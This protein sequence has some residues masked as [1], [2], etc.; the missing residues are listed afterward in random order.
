MSAFAY[1]GDIRGVILDHKV[2]LRGD[3]RANLSNSEQSSMPKRNK[4]EASPRKY[5][6]H[7][8]F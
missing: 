4:A 3:V 6:L 8:S 2:P 5:L 1:N 7:D